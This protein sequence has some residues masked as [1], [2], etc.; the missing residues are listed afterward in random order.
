LAVYALYNFPPFAVTFSTYETEELRAATATQDGSSYESY[1]Q[2]LISETGQHDSSLSYPIRSI[3]QDFLL[4]QFQRELGTMHQDQDED[5]ASIY[6]HLMAVDLQTKLYIVQDGTTE[7]VR[8]RR[9]TEKV[10]L[11]AEMYGTVAFLEPSDKT[12]KPSNDEVRVLFGNWLE[13]SFE[14]DRDQYLRELVQ[15]EQDLLREITSL[16][17]QTNIDIGIDNANDDTKSGAYVEGWSNRTERALLA[18]M[19]LLGIMGIGWMLLYLQQRHRIQKEKHNVIY[20]M[21]DNEHEHDYDDDHDH[22][23]QDHQQ[24][25]IQ[26]PLAISSRERNSSMDAV[27]HGDDVQHRHSHTGA[28]SVLEKSDRYLSKHRPDLYKQD[29]QKSQI[30]LMGRNYV[31]PSNP[32]EYIYSAFA[33]ADPP[34]PQELLPSPRG[35]FTPTSR[36][37]SFR[38]PN[39]AA[40]EEDDDDDDYPDDEEHQVMGGHV[41]QHSGYTPISTIWR[42]LSTMWDHAPAPTNIN[43]NDNDGLVVFQP[44]DQQDDYDFAFQDFPR[45]D[46]TPC[47]I[48]NDDA[49]HDK[50]QLQLR[51]VFS[52]GSHEEDLLDNNNNDGNDDNTTPVSDQAFQRMLSQHS[53]HSSFEDFPDLPA[54]SPQFKSKLERLMIQKHRQ[55]EKKSIVEKHRE[56]R[57]KER[58]DN[59]DQERRDRHKVMERELEALEKNFSSPLE[60]F[61]LS[62]ARTHYSPKPLTHTHTHQQHY[63]PQLSHLKSNPQYSPKLTY[64]HNRS[65]PRPP[66]SPKFEDSTTTTTTTTSSPAYRSSGIFRPPPKTSYGAA[67]GAGLGSSNSYGSARSISP[68]GGLEGQDDESHMFRTTK[69]AAEPHTLRPRTTTKPTSDLYVDTARALDSDDLYCDEHVSMD[70]LSMP[71]MN[72]NMN[73]TT[74]APKY[75]SPNSVMDDILTAPLPRNHKQPMHRRVQS[76]D[77]KQHRRVQSSGPSPNKPQHPLHTRTNSSSMTQPP[78][79]RR[80]ISRSNSNSSQTMTARAT[81]PHRRTHSRSNSHSEDVFLHAKNAGAGHGHGHNRSNSSSSNTRTTTPH[82]RTHSRSNSHSEDVFLHGIFAQTRFV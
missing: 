36:S 70:Y 3:T 30:H 35:A 69:S 16:S 52:I 5:H 20:G 49:E 80:S 54:K 43:T 48:Y 23:S 33:D 74:A 25:P 2:Y 51:R 81:T 26:R 18:M 14:H 79:Q 27:R 1:S 42:N 82:R 24:E 57:A 44:E 41:R 78:P 7:N 63:S 66:K 67:T 38:Q 15:S 59:R 21:E 76:F 29:S 65:S 19:I 64:R 75:P 58:K 8:R 55:Y 62:P 47:L 40:K 39:I 60:R 12:T 50:E 17:I 77:T 10:T 72:M 73:T 22:D 71:P 34:T 61:Q 11:V 45:H 31:I 4:E 13:A 37:S 6:N 68:P 28:I 46:G 9:V 32:F 56:L 53:I